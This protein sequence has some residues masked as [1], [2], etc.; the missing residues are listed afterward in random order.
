MSRMLQNCRDC[1]LADWPRSRSQLVAAQSQ[2]EGV[3][4]LV[5]FDDEDEGALRLGVVKVMGMKSAISDSGTANLLPLGLGPSGSQ[6]RR[7][8]TD[9]H[10]EGRAQCCVRCMR[11]LCR[12]GRARPGL[13]HDVARCQSPLVPGQPRTAYAEARQPSGNQ[14]TG[15]WWVMAASATNG[16]CQH[17]SRSRSLAGSSSGSASVKVEVWTSGT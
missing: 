3:S 8:Q 5:D 4:S 6:G 16:N 12:V 14:R 1:H 9:P 2:A 17:Y 10:V 11:G 13:K 7:E 15:L